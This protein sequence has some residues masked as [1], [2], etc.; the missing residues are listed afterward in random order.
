MACE[1]LGAKDRS[2]IL[3]NRAQAY[4]RQ[5]AYADAVSDC[6]ACLT[7]TPGT[8]KALYRRGCA[9]EALGNKADA[10]KDYREVVRLDATIHDAVLALRR[11]TSA[12]P[13]RTLRR[14]VRECR[15]HAPVI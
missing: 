9:Y 14:G 1:D 6:T 8:V 11:Y 2:I 10:I 5:K 12:P 13:G 3:C 7:L 15:R 4:L